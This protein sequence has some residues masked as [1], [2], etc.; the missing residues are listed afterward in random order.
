M[1]LVD[2]GTS[3]VNPYIYQRLVSVCFSLMTFD[4]LIFMVCSSIPSMDPSP[5]YDATGLSS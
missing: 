5:F 1:V 4:L 3:L 2:L